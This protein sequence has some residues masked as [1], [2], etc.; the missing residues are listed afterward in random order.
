MLI[1]DLFLFL[2]RSTRWPQCVR[3][4]TQSQGHQNTGTNAGRNECADSHV[5]GRIRRRF[6]VPPVV[7]I[8]DLFSVCDWN[9]DTHADANSQPLQITMN[10]VVLGS[11]RSN[12]FRAYKGG[13]YSISMV[14][15]PDR[16][17]CGHSCESVCVC[18]LYTHTHTQTMGEAV[19]V[20]CFFCFFHSACWAGKRLYWL[21]TAHVKTT[22]CGFPSD[23]L[24]S[25]AN[26][27][28]WPRS[29]KKYKIKIKLVN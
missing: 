26:H 28:T 19:H 21:P 12:L 29:L 4:L 1:F 11:Q 15:K 10:V 5:P 20:L 17:A 9:T 3:R 18:A 25:P 6:F 23:F 13:V 24:K 8:L 2:K 27:C 16:K 14:I 22:S 7:H